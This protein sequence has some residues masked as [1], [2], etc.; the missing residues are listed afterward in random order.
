VS[1]ASFWKYL[2]GLLPKEGHFTRIES[3]DTSAGFPDVHFT[4]PSSFHPNSGTIELKD[5]KRPG[6]KY[7]FKGESG[8]RK[9]QITWIRDEDEAGGQVLL[10]LQ[11]GD[12][13]YLLKAELYYDELHRMTEEQIKRVATVEWCKE[14]QQG[15]KYASKD[16]ITESLRDLLEGTL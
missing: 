13:V 7:P 11:C 10:A 4:F 9:S 15:K 3:H 16:A 1:E 12:R 5:A 6:A 2:R 8:L 14:R